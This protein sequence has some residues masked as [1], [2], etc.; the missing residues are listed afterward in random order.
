M[1][2]VFLLALLVIGLVIAKV[3]KLGSF[4]VVDAED[5]PPNYAAARPV[6]PDLDIAYTRYG[7]TGQLK[8]LVVRCDHCQTEWNATNA[9]FQ[10]SVMEA[11]HAGLQP[12]QAAFLLA[13]PSPECGYTGKVTQ[14]QIKKFLK[15]KEQ[16]KKGN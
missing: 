6:A 11:G 10:P 15:K 9:A 12:T 7:R 2:C 3:K 1:G 16:S 13:C 8:R 4:S 14:H 5:F